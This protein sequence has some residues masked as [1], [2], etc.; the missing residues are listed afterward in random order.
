MFTVCV[1]RVVVGLEISIDAQEAPLLPETS[2][3][4]CV[5][6]LGVALASAASVTTAD[7]TG[8]PVATVGLKVHCTYCAADEYQVWPPLL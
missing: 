5:V 6:P 3:Q 2:S 4:V 1:T 8:V 7:V